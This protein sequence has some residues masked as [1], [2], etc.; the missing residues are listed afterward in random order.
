MGARTG[1]GNRNKVGFF[2]LKKKNSLLWG[3]KEISPNTK[4]SF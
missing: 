2:T 3:G 1:A 4:I